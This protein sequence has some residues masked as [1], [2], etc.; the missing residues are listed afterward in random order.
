MEAESEQREAD[1]RSLVELGSRRLSEVG[2]LEHEA[3]V[4]L[5][6]LLDRAAVALNGNTHQ[7]TVSSDDGS[8]SI[9]ID[10]DVS[11]RVAT[12]ETPAGHL[13]MPDALITVRWLTNL[14]G[15]ER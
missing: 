14:G 4:V 10:Q 6:E 13:H 8:L 7:A 9:H 15:E 1:R 12:I 2:R 3:L 11:P 5:I